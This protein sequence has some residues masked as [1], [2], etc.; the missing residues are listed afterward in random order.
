MSDLPRRSYNAKAIALYDSGAMLPDQ[1]GVCHGD[2]DRPID[3]YNCDANH[4]RAC[5]IAVKYTTSTRCVKCTKLGKLSQF[6]ICANASDPLATRCTKIVP[7]G[8]RLGKD[9]CSV[10]EAEMRK[11][12]NRHCA[13]LCQMCKGAKTR[14]RV[15]GVAICSLCVCRPRGAVRKCIDDAKIMAAADSAEETG[16]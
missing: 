9:I 11:G 13:E 14:K 8:Y 12:S 2:G 6:K 4:C 5:G 7:S 10:C 1:H 15:E 3:W 16:L